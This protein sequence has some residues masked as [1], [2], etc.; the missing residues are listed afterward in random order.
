MIAS[1]YIHIPFCNK[2]CSYCDF[3][4]LYY[5]KNLVNRYLKELDNDIS[6]SYNNEVLKTIY[7]GG[8]TPG[9]LSLKELKYLFTI[10]SKLN[11]D[12]NYEYTIECNFDSIT[13]EKLDLFKEVGINRISFGLESINKGNLKLLERDISKKKVIDTINYCKEI[14]LNNINID[15][16]YAI[17]NETLDVLEKDL[18]FIL[19][20]DVPHISTYSLIIE[21]HTKLK[22][23][24]AKPIS[25]E[26][27]N[28]MYKLICTKLSKYN[29][30]EISNFAK[31]GYES[32]HNLTY[33]KNKE[34]YGFGLSSSGY[35]ENTR[36]TR[37]RSIT[38][39][40]DSNYINSKSIEYLSTKDKIE[41]EVILNLRLKE[42]INLIDF[43][44]KYN[45]LSNYYNY[46]K[47]VEKNLLVEEDNHLYIKEELWYISNSIIV[48]LLTEVI[49]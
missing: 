39:Y 41:Y 38:K 35:I 8:G 25:E 43:K 49:K 4:K 12:S 31:K 34:Y 42:G 18:D 46:H 14:G 32:K 15:L 24:K 2:I 45:D 33:W 36:Y 3:C 7:I 6:N 28:D 30:Y 48:E 27:D 5:D 13:K 17:P 23:N 16:I 37:T 26:L 44:S 29:H 11:K 20:L 47:L 1:A 21:D 22:I 40:L 9:A 19:S 10:I